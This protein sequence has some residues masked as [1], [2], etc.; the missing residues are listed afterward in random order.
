M[1]IGKRCNLKK[2]KMTKESVR[3]FGLTQKLGKISFIVIILNREVQLHVPRKES[4]P[5]PLSNVDFIRSPYADLEIAQEN[6]I[7]DCWDVEK[8][9]NLSESWTGFQKNYVIERNSFERALPTREEIHE[10]LN[11]IMYRSKWRDAL[12]RIGKAAQRRKKQE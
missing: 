10:N 9:R 3:I 1:A 12:T 7:Y 5:I 11:D 6:R 2:Q 4:Y 8:N